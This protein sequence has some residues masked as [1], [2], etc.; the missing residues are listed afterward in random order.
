MQPP[1]SNPYTTP[2]YEAYRK[3]QKRNIIIAISIVV[4]VVIIGISLFVYFVMNV[5]KNSDAYATALKEI[6]TNKQVKEKTGGIIGFDS[7]PSGTISTTNGSGTAHFEIG[8]DGR[9]KDVEVSVDLSKD[10]GNDW[11][12]DNLEI[13]E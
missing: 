1:Y 5:L 2:A 7:F 3:K 12:V 4:P 11:K 9:D 6:T 10:S 8:I 13:T